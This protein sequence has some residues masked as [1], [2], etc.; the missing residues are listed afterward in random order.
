MAK[1]CLPEQFIISLL[2]EEKLVVSTQS[3]IYLT[4]P[5]EIG[6]VIPATVAVVQEQNHALADVYEHANVAAASIF[7]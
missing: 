5:V 7:C 3:R 4:V 2:I 6:C 1:P